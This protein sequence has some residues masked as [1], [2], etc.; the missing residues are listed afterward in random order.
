MHPPPPLTN[1]Q[2]FPFRPDFCGMMKGL[3]VP[4][5]SRA[6]RARGGPGDSEWFCSMRARPYPIRPG[7]ANRV[8]VKRRNYGTAVSVTL[9]IGN[10]GSGGESR[11]T[12]EEECARPRRGGLTPNGPNATGHGENT[13][14]TK[15]INWLMQVDSGRSPCLAMS[16][17]QYQSTTHTTHTDRQR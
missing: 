4:S 2:F 7:E 17:W 5:G 8:G 9:R 11:D 12:C 15:A 13:T 6:R 16:I 1:S 14:P 10:G 3:A